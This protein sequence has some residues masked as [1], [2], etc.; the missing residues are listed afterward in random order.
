[1]LDELD[2]GARIGVWTALGVVAFVIFG[3]L[4]GIVLRQIHGPAPAMAMAETAA[5]APAAAPAAV[6]L[7]EFLDIPLAGD[8]AGTLF[9][10]LDSTEITADDQVRLEAIRS[11]AAAAPARKLVISGFHD[12]SGAIEHNQDLAK[13]RAFAVR[14][15]LAAMGVERERLVLRKPESTLG[16]GFDDPQGRRVEV[17]LVD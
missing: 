3:L 15:A 7:G 10:A 6:D 16:G 11:A 4:G 17:H 14:D 12:G 8:L 13:R 2:D 5:P 1:M 9:F